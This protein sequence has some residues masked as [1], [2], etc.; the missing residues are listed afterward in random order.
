MAPGY[1]FEGGN[2]GGNASGGIGWLRKAEEESDGGLHRRKHLRR[3]LA[4]IVL[5]SAT[6]DRPDLMA[7]SR[8]NRLSRSPSTLRRSD[9]LSSDT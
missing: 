1:A 6:I 8:G 2:E 3:Q 7:V 9:V 4:Q 5:K